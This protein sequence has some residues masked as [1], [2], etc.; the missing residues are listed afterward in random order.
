MATTSASRPQT[1]AGTTFGKN[2]NSI[3]HMLALVSREQAFIQNA[4]TRFQTSL[5]GV[6][7]EVTR[8]RTLAGKSP[9]PPLL[10]LQTAVA[11]L[12]R[13]AKH[14]KKTR[15]IGRERM[16]TATL[17]QVVILVTC[18]EAYLQDLLAIAA[19][20]DPKLM[21]DSQRIVSCAAVIS[22]TSLNELV[23]GMS[24]Q[25]A[26]GWLRKGGPTSWISRLETIGV[27]GYPDGLV[28]RLELIWDVRHLVVHAAGI[29]TA[30]F[31]KRHPG[32]AATAGVHI[33]LS[34][35]EDSFSAFI[36]SVNEFIEPT[37]RYFVKR[38]P[39]LL[40]ETVTERVK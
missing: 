2:L 11:K 37:E 31:I 6:T 1:K 24:T 39:S 14:Y 12:T 18:V 4:S 20:V 16:A 27:R 35:E 10:P 28:P 17:W 19:S 22:A 8:I 29:A 40:D 7:T 38:C 30:D 32:F 25:W 3:L 26:R 21:A 13:S 5:A 9:N 23:S 36:D 34:L 33:R 15:Q